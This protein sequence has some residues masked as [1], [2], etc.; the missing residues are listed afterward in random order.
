MQSL[1]WGASE[2]CKWILYPEQPLSYGSDG[3]VL[4]FLPLEL[5]S[6]DMPLLA[7]TWFWE[8]NIDV[9]EGNKKTLQRKSCSFKNGL[10]GV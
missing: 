6:G 4:G 5:W 8:A 2:V 1:K 3:M 10:G 9:F 7:L